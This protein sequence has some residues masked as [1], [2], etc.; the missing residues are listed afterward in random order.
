MKKT[1]KFKNFYLT[2]TILLLIPI[3]TIAQTRVGSFNFA[4]Y[5][6]KNLNTKT[7]NRFNNK[8]TKFILPEFYSKSSY[9]NLLKEVWNVTPYEIVSQ[10]DFNE[11]EVKVDDVLAQFLSLTITKT[12]KSGSVVHYLYNILD[13]HVVDKLRKSSRRNPLKW[14]SSKIGT[15]YFTPGIELR[16][17]VNDRA[18][19]LT[20][21]L[22]NFRLGYLKNYLQLMNNSIKN[23]ISIN[24][25][26]DFSKPELSKLK[27]K[28]LYIDKNFIYG[29]NAWTISKKKSPDIDELMSNYSYKYEFIEYENLE[30]MIMNKDTPDFYY[31]M[32]NQ[33][34][35]NKI[36]NIINGKTG[37]IIYQEH[38]T[39]SYNLKPKDFKTLSSEIN[40]S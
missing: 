12:T 18:K 20:G 38:S 11:N 8:T 3:S 10:K 39:I 4:E 16:E 6:F 32:Y 29:Y 23:K 2:I 36:L 15:I 28:I 24:L 19:E 30:K 5:K 37:E 27:T 25:Y 1:N 14:Y 35:S 31:F 21:D 9:E 40:K 26:D 17:Q 34:N 7:L 13:F 33:I 22:L